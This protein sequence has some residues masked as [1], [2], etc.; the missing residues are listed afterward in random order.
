MAQSQAGGELK[1]WPWIPDEAAAA[2][3]FDPAIAWPRLTVIT[4]SFNQAEFLET[5]LRSVLLQGYPN[6]EYLVYDGGSSD[7][8]VRILE[9][10][11]DRLSYWQSAPDGGQSAAINAGFARGSGEVFNWLN[12]DDYLLPGALRRVA[13]A[14]L[15]AGNP[16]AVYAGAGIRVD[17][18]GRLLYRSPIRRPGGDRSPFSTPIIGGVQASWF[19]TRRLWDLIGGLDDS[20]DFAMDVDLH[21]KLISS[22]GDLVAID[23]DLAAF[24]VH[25]EAKTSRDAFPAVREREKLMR[26]FLGTPAFPDDARHRAWLRRDIS[27][28]ALAWAKRAPDFRV[29]L[30]MVLY[31]FRLQPE[32]LKRSDAWRMALAALRA[33]LAGPP[34]P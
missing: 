15:E 8:S 24:R 12:S 33:Q 2:E 17:A 25:G 21:L 28:L 6:L 1:G 31:A 23:H 34:P 5:T 20:L 29:A 11:Q 7:G 27:G 22:P 16:H 19:W 26:S 18:E 3:E 32:R 14:H 13:L 30:A 10:Y 9:R 4:P